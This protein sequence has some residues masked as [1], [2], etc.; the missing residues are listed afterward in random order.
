[1]SKDN[2]DIADEVIANFIKNF[3]IPL[4]DRSIVWA[5]ILIIEALE[6]KEKRRRRLSTA[7]LYSP[8]ETL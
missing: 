3:E 6:I 8:D 5:R 7:P 1:M 4:N 2:R